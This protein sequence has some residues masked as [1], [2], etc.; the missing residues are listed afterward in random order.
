M[1]FIME[2]F[3]SS[4]IGNS[5]N[6]VAVQS[7]P[8]QGAPT[9]KIRFLTGSAI[10]LGIAS[11]VAA[12]AT[13]VFY[14][15]PLVFPFFHSTKS[16]VVAAVAL[17]GALGSITSLVLRHI[18]QKKGNVPDPQTRE[19][20]EKQIE[21]L[22][23]LVALEHKNNN[24][25]Y[26]IK[27]ELEKQVEHLEADNKELNDDYDKLD[28]E[29]WTLNDNYTILYN[30]YYL[31]KLAE[32]NANAAAKVAPSGSGQSTEGAPST[33][34]SAAAVAVLPAAQKESG[35]NPITRLFGGGKKSTALPAHS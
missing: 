29:K 9:G 11:V 31:P 12:V 18:V 17:T 16:L 19:M 2:V 1:P 4:A 28:D 14:Q 22:T 7:A 30:Q 32:E 33:T 10:V 20:L 21:G 26:D 24:V 27:K 25:L 3:M 34:A 35:G 6:N 8:A 23:T 5:L 15:G 13:V